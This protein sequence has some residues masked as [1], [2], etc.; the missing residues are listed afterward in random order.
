[1]SLSGSRERSIAQ[2]L[3]WCLSEPN[4]KAVLSLQADA[5]M[6]KSS[7]LNEI[8]RRIRSNSFETPSNRAQE[9]TQTKSLHAQALIEVVS[10]SAPLSSTAGSSSMEA[11]Q[12]W[13]QALQ[14]LVA[15]R[16]EQRLPTLVK[17]L[18]IAWIKFVPVVGDLIESAA[19]TIELLRDHREGK[20][21]PQTE[22]V[23]ALNQQQVFQQ[24][25]NVLKAVAEQGVFVICIDD[26]HWADD[27]SL[28][29]L[30][31]AA[32]Q[33][34]GTQVRFLL[35]HRPLHA[36]GH[37]AAALQTVLNELDRYDLLERMELDALDASDVD[38]LL[39]ER[40][41][42]AYQNNDELET[43]I[44]TK[45]GGNPLFITAWLSELERAEIL[46]P[47]NGA[48][49]KELAN[50]S[51]PRTIEAILE[52]RISAVPPETRE[53]LRYASV[54][55]QRFSSIMVQR[56]M[57]LP[58][59]KVLQ[60]LR[61][62]SDEQGLVIAR[63]KALVYS[64]ESSVFEFS[65]PLIRD[66]LYASLHQEERELL[67]S[68]HCD[69]IFAARIP[70][71]TE[72]YQR[73]FA[74]QLWYHAFESRRFLDAARAGIALAEDA[75]KV[76]SRRE[77]QQA[78][79]SCLD[80]LS[81]VTESHDSIELSARAR[82]LGAEVLLM[83]TQFSEAE[84]EFIA[85]EQLYRRID[86]S[87]SAV[88]CI[89]RQA[90]CA[91]RDLRTDNCEAHCR[92][93]IVEAEQLHY[94]RGQASAYALLGIV[95]ETRGDF[96]AAENSYHLAIDTAQNHTL[97]VTEA[98]ARANLARV[99]HVQARNAES[100]DLASRALDLFR[101]QSH[102]PG[103]TRCLNQLGILHKDEREF[104]RAIAC[105]E[106]AMQLD[107]KIGD[108]DGAASVT[109]NIGICYFD[110]EHFN[111]ALP[112]F[113]RSLRLKQQTHDKFGAGVALHALGSCLDKLRRSSEAHTYHVQSI[114]TFKAI[115]DPMWIANAEYGMAMH[116]AAQVQLA[117]AEEVLK[118]AR[119]RALSI[120]AQTTLDMIDDGFKELERLKSPT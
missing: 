35:S 106:E 114:E 117:E 2:I 94:A 69:A 67:H 92:R 101:E 103:Q 45:S 33:L 53:V 10:C 44:A 102:I 34:Q 62:C 52:E 66:N 11:L 37:H 99:M 81:K 48:A 6:G 3:D 15:Q 74:S 5:G 75:W 51:V 57:E 82:E 118:R 13:A 20:A 80:A 71:S 98:S 108:L 111:E 93:A 14:H 18:A 107:E 88:D 19:D 39:R 110:Q 9:N 16:S 38:R 40:Y 104:S 105:F 12:P 58:L 65:H 89:L 79:R 87:H 54:E 100:L 68:A 24:Y 119:S 26:A 116:L 72:P 46:D 49:L 61:K 120:H 42:E 22:Q 36:A 23:E 25:I 113:E 95:F 29:L 1:M 28:N 83:D 70:E 41:A 78:L 50:I 32:R 47:S 7:L 109:T 112:Y 64:M 17:D 76:Y 77:C 4:H 55:G 90:A 59:L 86:N 63:D 96:T 91:S 30:F 31:T 56:T 85:A 43:F 8:Q 84:G 60:L 27:S 73:A 97:T 115:D 21:R